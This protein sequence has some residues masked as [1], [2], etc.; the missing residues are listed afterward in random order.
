M[1]AYRAVFGHVDN[2]LPGTHFESRQEV[3]EAR[4]HKERELENPRGL[5][6]EGERA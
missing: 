3:K 1:A 5:D 2:I 6:D 4:L